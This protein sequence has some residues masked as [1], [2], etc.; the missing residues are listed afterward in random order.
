[1]TWTVILGADAA[2]DAAWQV[3]C[4]QMSD[5]VRLPV[6]SP[7]QFNFD[8]SPLLQ[9]YPPAQTRV[10]V[11]LDARALNVA[12]HQ[13]I[14]Q[15]QLA[16]YSLT[17]L[18]STTALVDPD[19]RIAPNVYIGPGSSIGPGC[20][21]GLGCWL[22]R[23]VMLERDVSLGAC[24]SLGSAVVLAPQVRV[25]LGSTLGAGSLALAGSEVGKRCEWLLGA[26]L[27]RHLPD[28]SLYDDLM[29]EGARIYRY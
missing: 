8:L 9:H 10:F 11:A 19:V 23:R 26:T 20:S 16:G 12:R 25:G 1:M 7:D 14:A 4:E 5:A 18:V 6:Q 3:A 28:Y 29:P 22:D 24:V 15:V 2:L 13:L 21:L 17:H 27:P